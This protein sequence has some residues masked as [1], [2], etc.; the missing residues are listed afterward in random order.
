MGKEGG[1]EGEEGRRE[2]GM[3]GGTKSFFTVRVRICRTLL[4]LYEHTQ[5]T[6]EVYYLLRSNVFACTH[7]L[8]ENVNP[9]QSH[10]KGISLT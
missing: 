10:L 7:P 2:R 9:Q 5:L 1:M 3:D 6:S 8:F 4:S